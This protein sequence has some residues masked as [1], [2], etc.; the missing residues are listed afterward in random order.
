MSAVQVL[1]LEFVELARE[2]VLESVTLALEQAQEPVA[3]ALALV[4]AQSAALVLE[5]ERALGPRV[6]LGLGRV[7]QVALPRVYQQ[8]L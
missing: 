6:A 7:E 5:L 1:G 2:Q 4:R 8:G 3:S